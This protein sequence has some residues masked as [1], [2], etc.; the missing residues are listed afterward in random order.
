MRRREFIGLVGGAVVTSPLGG[1]AQQRE[2]VRRV[3]VLQGLAEGDLE[4]RT[5]LAA[6][7]QGLQQLGWSDGRNVQFVE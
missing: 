3:G 7:Y 2:R 4:G 5:N 1:R 6:F